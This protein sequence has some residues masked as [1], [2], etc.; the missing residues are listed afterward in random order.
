MHVTHRLPNLPN[1]EHA[2]AIEHLAEVD[3]GIRAGQFH[4]QQEGLGQALVQGE[5]DDL[6]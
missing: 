3:G 2:A 4:L 6:E 1:R 5:L